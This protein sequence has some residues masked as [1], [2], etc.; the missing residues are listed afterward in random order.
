LYQVFRYMF[1]LTLTQSLGCIH[2]LKNKILATI[3]LKYIKIYASRDLELYVFLYILI[4]HLLNFCLFNLCMQPDEC[5]N[6]SRNM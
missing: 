4:L 1:R 5:V 3:I 2:K 6:V